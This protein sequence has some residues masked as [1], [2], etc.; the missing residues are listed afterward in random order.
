M[1]TTAAIILAAGEST[2]MGRLKALLPW[3]GKPLV[4]YQVDSL[5][6]AGV[7]RTIVVL[8]H[9]SRKLESI[10]GQLPAVQTVFNPNYAQ[11]KTTSL[12]AGL[13]A[14]R[15]AWDTGTGAPEDEAILILNVDQPRLPGVIRQLL[16]IHSGR[17][18]G[19]HGEPP[20][21][22]IPTYRGKGGHPLI[23]STFLMPE[24]LEISEDTL[25]IKAVVRRHKGETQRVEMDAPEVLF[26]LNTPEDY[27]RASDEL[28]VSN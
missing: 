14:L 7:S 26:D 4:Q 13:Y 28:S 3:Q 11:G 21:I 10:L 20:L 2:R 9:Q 16:E 22:T 1:A 18:T 5:A 24:L 17:A 23:L 8:G 6:S 15:K 19:A 27:R 12:N 25:G